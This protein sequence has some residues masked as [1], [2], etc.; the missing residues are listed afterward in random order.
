MEMAVISLI[1][2]FAVIGIA[3]IAL[4]IGSLIWAYRN[5]QFEDVEGVARRVL[6]VDK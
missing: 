4:P 2:I 6:D 5:G 1:I 3:F